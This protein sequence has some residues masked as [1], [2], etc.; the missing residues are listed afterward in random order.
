M[1]MFLQ[2]TSLAQALGENVANEGQMAIQM[3]E[4]TANR[5]N[6]FEMAAKGGWIMIVLLVLSLICFYIDRCR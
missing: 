4:E 3:A 1:N 2:T 5:M 6:L